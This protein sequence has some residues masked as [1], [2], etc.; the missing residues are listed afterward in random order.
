MFSRRGFMKGTLA[1]AGVGAGGISLTALAAAEPT[2]DPIDGEYLEKYR[3]VF[4][5]D[6]LEEAVPRQ[7]AKHEPDSVGSLILGY[8]KKNRE[9]GFRTRLVAFPHHVH[10]HAGGLPILVGG[11]RM[12]FVS[13]EVVIRYPRD[14]IDEV[15]KSRT[16]NDKLRHTPRGARTA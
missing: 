3:E 16:T 4:L 15:L 6:L 1:V 2:Y 8:W 10:P 11:M 5:Q 12:V 7:I 9:D 13:D 14:L